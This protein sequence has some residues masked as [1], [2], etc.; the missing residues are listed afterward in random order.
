MKMSRVAR[1]ESAA[2]AEKETAEDAAK[3]FLLY[4]VFVE[5]A[6]GGVSDDR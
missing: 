4:A 6:Q 1:R 5:E 2:L 3:L